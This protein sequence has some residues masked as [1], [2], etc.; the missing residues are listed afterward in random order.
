MNN[1]K[2]LSILAIT[3]ICIASCKSNKALVQE[4]VTTATKEVREVKEEI[5]TTEP[6]DFLNGLTKANQEDFHNTTMEHDGESIPVYLP[7]GKRVKGMEL[8]E[9]LTAVD[10]FPE[11]YV[12]KENEIAAYVVRK[13]IDEDVKVINTKGTMNSEKSRE[14]GAMN[15]PLEILKKWQKQIR[16]IPK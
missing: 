9:A 15:D 1:L 13:D 5:T 7:D 10:F 16:K 12:N 2:V 8:V 6:L 4:E 14:E 3:I 11:I